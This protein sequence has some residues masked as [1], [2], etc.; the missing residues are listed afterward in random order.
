MDD[1]ALDDG[2]IASIGSYQQ[3][4]PSAEVFIVD[5]DEDMRELLAA[6]VEPLGYPVTTFGDADSFLSATTSKVPICI[7]LDFIM[8][9]RSGLDVLKELRARNYQAPIFLV[10]A[11]DDLPMAVEGMK[12]GAHDFI[13]KPFDQSAVALRVRSAIEMW[14]S[15]VQD[16]PA[17]QFRLNENLE[18]FRLTPAEKEMV[19]LSRFMD[20]Q[21][22]G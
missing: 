6:S 10:S 18:W 12:F 9:R 21:A 22:A 1:F 7:F 5:D 17:G 3:I 14:V 20:L 13:K 16:S 19:M 2:L 11:L 15:R 8:P 4:K